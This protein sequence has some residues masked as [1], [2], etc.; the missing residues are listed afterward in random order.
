MLERECERER[1]CDGAIA[2]D[3]MP[4]ERVHSSC[5]LSLPRRTYIG[6]A[7]RVHPFDNTR[8]PARAQPEELAFRRNLWPG[9]DRNTAVHLSGP[10]FGS[11]LRVPIEKVPVYLHNLC[12]A[13][14]SA[15][16]ELLVSMAC[17]SPWPVWKYCRACEAVYCFAG[18]C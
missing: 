12:V 9:K 15:T 8:A 11:R 6:F 16:G 3:A 1:E 4:A 7:C 13:P 2:F 18:D 14:G 5:I 17:R 10:T